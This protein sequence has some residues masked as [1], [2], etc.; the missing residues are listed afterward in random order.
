VF[1]EPGRNLPLFYAVI[2]AIALP[3][4]TFISDATGFSE[5]SA[6]S[7]ASSAAIGAVGGFIGGVLRRR[8][9][10]KS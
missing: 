8:K 3:I 1:K 6:G 4:G 10:H 9:T 2:G 7:Y 5:A